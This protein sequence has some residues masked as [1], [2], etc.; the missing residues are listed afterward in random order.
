MDQKESYISLAA[1]DTARK[2]K[3]GWS[4]VMIAAQSIVGLFRIVSAAVREMSIFHWPIR[5]PSYLKTIILV[6]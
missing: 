5:K 6:W 4:M 3:Y 2:R 1:A